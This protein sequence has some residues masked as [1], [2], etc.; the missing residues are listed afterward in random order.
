MYQ[1]LFLTEYIH[2]LPFIFIS[3]SQSFT[4]QKNILII[5]NTND[6]GAADDEA[7]DDENAEGEENVDRGIFHPA[8]RLRF[9]LE[10][11]FVWFVFV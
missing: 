4:L 6:A 2:F 5:P 8:H 10:F 7:E 3:Y 11:V 1:V 9:P